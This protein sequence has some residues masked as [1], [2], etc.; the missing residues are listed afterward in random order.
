MGSEIVYKRQR[1]TYFR[2]ALLNGLSSINFL[3]EWVAYLDTGD[4]SDVSEA[5]GSLLKALLNSEEYQTF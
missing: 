2:D 1:Y 5:L 4:D 3:F